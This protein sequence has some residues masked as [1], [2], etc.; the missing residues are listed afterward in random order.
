M[1]NELNN[2]QI[3]TVKQNDNK[4]TAPL[5]LLLAKGRFIIDKN[6]T[7]EIEAASLPVSSLFRKTNLYSLL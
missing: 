5:H 1:D 3:K 7:R 4:K 6:H 2:R